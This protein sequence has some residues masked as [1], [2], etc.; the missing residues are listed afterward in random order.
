MNTFGEIRE[1]SLVGIIFV[2]P[3]LR[4]ALRLAFI[5]FEFF[6]RVGVCAKMG[7]QGL[8]GMLEENFAV[9]EDE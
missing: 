3:R 5:V 6:L 7:W 2:G 9:L 8:F 1:F 4:R